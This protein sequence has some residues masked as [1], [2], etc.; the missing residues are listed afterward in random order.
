MGSSLLG[1]WLGRRC[2]FLHLL[3]ELGGRCSQPGPFHPPRCTITN[4]KQLTSPRRGTSFPF[5]IA[6][7]PQP[8]VT[9]GHRWCVCKSSDLQPICGTGCLLL[10]WRA[11]ACPP[12]PQYTLSVSVLWD[13][14]FIIVLKA[15]GF[16]ILHVIQAAE[17]SYTE[18][19]RSQ[20]ILANFRTRGRWTVKCQWAF[21]K[22]M[23][24][25][26]GWSLLRFAS[27]PQDRHFESCN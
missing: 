6:L 22:E 18:G 7:W 14:L 20:R 3:G 25:L 8:T 15:A 9:G 13:S 5:P 1:C 2:M 21:R 19:L 16:R 12:H 23:H 27:K 11:V 24:S 17:L 26:S 10:S 4:L